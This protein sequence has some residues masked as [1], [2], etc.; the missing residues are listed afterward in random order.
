MKIILAFV[1]LFS[2]AVMANKEPPAVLKKGQLIVCPTSNKAVY[3]M[4]K[5]LR[6]GDSISAD[7]LLDLET[8]KEA[9]SGGKIKCNAIAS[10]GIRG[11][12]Y[13]TT[14]GWVPVECQRHIEAHYEWVHTIDP[15]EK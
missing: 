8:G 4:L 9:A 14:S 6:H 2:S 13:F 15:A 11:T 7:K 1:L 3:K 10:F 12:C 5:T